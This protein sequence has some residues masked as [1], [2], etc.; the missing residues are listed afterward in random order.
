MSSDGP[1]SFEEESSKTSACKGLCCVS[2]RRPVRVEAVRSETALFLF[3]SFVFRVCSRREIGAKKFGFARELFDVVV[4]R[5][6]ESLFESLKP[7]AFMKAPNQLSP[8]ALEEC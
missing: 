7:I 3:F 6:C 4:D 8:P 1:G 5:F 2:V